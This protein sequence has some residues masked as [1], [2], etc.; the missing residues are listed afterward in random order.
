MS[1]EILRKRIYQTI[2]SYLGSSP[3]ARY[4]GFVLMIDVESVTLLRPPEA[5]RAHR[6]CYLALTRTTWRIDKIGGPIIQSDESG[7]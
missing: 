5:K 1:S 6:T 3:S 2:F 4:L 7:K